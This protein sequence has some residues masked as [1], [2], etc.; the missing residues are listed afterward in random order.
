MKLDDLESQGLIERVEPNLGNVKRALERAQRGLQ[1]E[2]LESLKRK[3][4]IYS[5]D[6]ALKS[7]SFLYHKKG[8]R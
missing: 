5:K 1:R 6:M 7:S 4:E 2:F 8:H 3:R